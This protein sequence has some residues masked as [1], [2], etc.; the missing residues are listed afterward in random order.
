MECPN[1]PHS[2]LKDVLQKLD[3]AELD[4]FKRVLRTYPLPDALKQIPQ[5]TLNL[6][7]GVQLAE[8][9]TE[10][11]PSGWV[12]R[13]TLQIL[14]ELNREDLAMLVAIQMEQAPLKAP[15]KK[16]SPFALEHKYK[17]SWLDKYMNEWRYSFWPTCNERLYI[18]TE[19]YRTLMTLC[20]P[21]AGMPFAHAIVLH[22]PPHSGKTTVVKRL[23]LQW[24]ESKQAQMFPCAFYISCGV[25]NETK[26]CTFVQLLT[27][28]KP[29]WKNYV[30]KSLAMG[31]NFLFVVDG[32]DELKFPA[33]T[34][35]HDICG[36]WNTEKPAV[37]LLSSLLQRKMAPHA[38]LLVTTQTKALRQIH[39]MMDQPFL[40]EIQGFSER[41]RQEYFQ[42]FFKNLKYTNRE[43]DDVRALRAFNALRGSAAL[44]HMAS[45]PS[46]CSIFCVCLDQ[47]MR[48][49]EDLAQTCQTHTSMF[50]NF[51]FRVLSPETYESCLKTQVQSTFRKV[52]IL[53]ADTL[54]EQLHV[55]CKEDLLRV[56][57]NPSSMHFLDCRN[58]VDQKDESQCYTFYHL[59]V[60]QLMAAIIFVQELEKEDKHVSKYSMQKL[61]SREARLKNPNL[62]GVLLFVFGLLNETRLQKLG[63]YFDFQISIRVKRK[64]LEYKSGEN[65]PFPLL[66]DR[67]QILSCLYESQDKGLVKEVMDLFEE[68]SLDLKTSTD[69][70]N[71]SFCLK[72]SQNLQTV[73]LQV[74][75]GIFPENDAV[76]ES[77]AQYQRSQDSQHLLAFWTDFCDLFN[78]NE[79]LVYLNIS[80]SF[81]SRSSL[82]ILCE[83]LSSAP[84]HLQKVLLKNIS[85]ANAY[86]KLCLIFNGYETLSHLTLKGD[87]LSTILP[88]LCEVMKH[89][90]CNLKFLSLCS[91]P[92]GIQKWDDFF[93]AIKVRQSLTCLD[94]TDNE[95]LDKGARLMCK[96][97]K[98]PNSTLQRVSLENCHLTEAC[99]KDISS[100][101]MV[102]QALTHLNLAKNV[103][104]DNGVKVLCE[105]LSYPECKLQTLVLWSCN[106]TSE[107]CRHLSKMLSQASSLEHLDLGQNCIRTP[108]TRFLCEALKEPQSNL[109]SLWLYG[110][111]MTPNNCKDFSET[112]RNNK[113]LNTIDLSQNNLGTDA[114]KTFCED[115]KHNICPLQTLRL[116]FDDTNP[117]I[118][119]L[120]QEMKKS[121]PQ[122]TISN[123]RSDPKRKGSSLPHFIF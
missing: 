51:L 88:S 99:C 9:L 10:Y 70:I 8:I 46:A 72:N 74:A 22:G 80:K 13:L 104:G 34:L 67:Q 7:N 55:V 121:H 21:K 14:K 32:F 36:D 37:V 82:E 43:S 42:I 56:E 26:P 3:Q 6:A 108:G 93:Q 123:D 64:L 114:V 18:E 61:L 49:R 122:L 4:N 15:G 17:K 118:Q 100:I 57:V 87:N 25:I 66:I 101:L 81:F 91:Y 2:N 24:S 69:L 120:I 85:P 33:E 1:L 95:L 92:T 54:L 76:L 83:K 112:L 59:S 77:T 63:T 75:K 27:M 94:L 98:Q 19:S 111:S 39:L 41:E 78:S 12:E 62:S 109:K 73:S 47:G 113:S 44:F 117:S 107:G 5:I 115:L 65:K 20:N 40:V 58:I 90:A 11:C 86:K 31:E 50:L 96:T 68:I 35:M 116:K 97:W 71:A 89:P 103:L 48:K 79:K 53:A 38:T 30:M 84:C 23:M 28:E 60:Q 110:C 119:K 52:C 16:D 106:I 45:L 102:S 29:S 105:S